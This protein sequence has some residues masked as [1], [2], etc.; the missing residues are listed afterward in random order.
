MAAAAEVFPFSICSAFHA[1]AI[2]VI[3]ASFIPPP[4]CVPAANAIS[5]STYI[6]A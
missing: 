3:G 6:Y 4:P 5:T 1:A 2:V